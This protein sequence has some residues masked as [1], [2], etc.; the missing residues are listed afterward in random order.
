MIKN[1]FDRL[2]YYCLHC[3]HRWILQSTEYIKEQQIQDWLKEI[4]KEHYIV[5]GTYRDIEGGIEQ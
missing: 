5:C 4:D 1:P 3:N 2:K